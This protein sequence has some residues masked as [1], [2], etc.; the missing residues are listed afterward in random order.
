[1]CGQA[2]HRVCVCGTL[3]ARGGRS[4]V[5]DAA[6]PSRPSPLPHQALDWPY[7]DYRCNEYV[8][9]VGADARVD[10]TMVDASLAIATHTAQ[11]PAA[12]PGCGAPLRAV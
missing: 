5:R 3:S 12:K 9:Q 10:E 6:V 7:R 2:I 4:R 1:M 11:P 8:S